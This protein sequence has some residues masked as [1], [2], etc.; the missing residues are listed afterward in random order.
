MLILMVS[1]TGAEEIILETLD[2]GP[3]ILPFK[4]GPARIITHYHSFL[5]TVD[6]DNIRTNLEMVKIQINSFKPQLNNKTL[7]LYDPH[8]QYLTTKLEKLSDQLKSF[9]PNRSKR[10]LIDGLGSVI[11]SISGNLDYTDALRYDSAIKTLQ[12]SENKIINEINNHMSLNKQWVLHGSDA[13]A[14]LVLN[15][16]KIESIVNNILIS[17]ARHE[18]SLVKYAHLAQLLIIL[19]DNIDYLHSELISLENMLAFIRVKSTH[20]SMINYQTFRDMIDRLNKLYRKEEILEIHFRDYFDIVKPGYY[21]KNN[22]I[23][24]VY[25]IPIVYPETYN[26]FKLSL[27][28]NGDNKILL[29]SFPYVAIH[30][31]G[32]MYIEAECPKANQWYLCE[33][34]PNHQFGEHPDCIQRLISKQL[35]DESCQFTPVSLST[36]AMEELD[37]KHYIVSFPGPTKVHLSC[38]QSQYRM[39]KG[40]YLLTVPRGCVM[41]TSKFTITNSHDRIR[42]HVLKI[43]DLPIIKEDHYNTSSRTLKLNS[44]DLNNLHSSYTKI[45]QQ[46]PVPLTT[47]HTD[48]LYH[49]T[50]PTYVIL[51]SATTLAITLA[52][53]RYLKKNKDNRNPVPETNS[54]GED[55]RQDDYAEIQEKKDKIQPRGSALFSTKVSK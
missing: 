3:G 47:W 9:E 18:T 41:K 13:I 28:P 7:S 51:F 44:I 55:S 4:L 23:V 49:T 37:D 39:M 38:S 35:I 50:I 14:K 24:L 25:Q 53:R 46:E 17:D 33:D 42:G 15:Q 12:E 45:T 34:K 22:N 32:F 48:S 21:Y 1:L 43:T 29:P 6:L 16:K 2:N 40:S 19:S 20:H 31:K 52:Y 36:E 26:L 5:Q 30:D 8:V 27:A 11:K 10:G 54:K